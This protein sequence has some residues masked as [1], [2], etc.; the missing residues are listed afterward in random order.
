[1]AKAN[2]NFCG[3]CEEFS[4]YKKSRYAIIPVPY[5]KTTTYLKGTAK[6]P[7]AMIEASRY[8]ELYDEELDCNPAEAGITT[9]KPLNIKDKPEKMVE[10]VRNACLKVINDGK[11]PIV[12][13]GEHSISEG[14][15]LALKE[16]HGDIS[17]LQFDAHA[18]LRDSHK[19][20]RHN[21]ACVMARIREHADA[22]QVG[23]RSLSDEEAE[24]V[25]EK[26]CKI[27]FAKDMAG[28]DRSDEI[29]A[30]LKE[31]VFITFDIDALDP[32]II[33]ATGTPEPGGLGWYES[34]NILRKVFSQRE[35]VGFDIMELRP[36]RESGPSDFTAAK[37]A[38]KMIGYSQM[39]KK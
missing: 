18:D 37:L 7:Q 23:I 29:T 11:Y 8:L 36:T 22:V 3:L 25:K 5:E 13:G 34:L 26:A 39:R 32:S 24:Y 17:V 12:F 14:L 10:K 1:M 28:R 19:G 6:G 21:H 30:S 35:V 4:D 2:P 9:L 27:F 33:P 31:K 38:Y 20:S 15:L 16:R